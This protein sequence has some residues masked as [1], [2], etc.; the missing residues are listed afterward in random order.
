[1]TSFRLERVSELLREVASEIIRELK[2]PRLGFVTI[3]NVIVS[4]DIRHA[5]I[6]VSIMGNPDEKKDS[7]AVLN[8][9]RGF[10]RR[11]TGKRIRIKHIPELA[12]INDESIEKGSR[13]LD[14]I[15]KVTRPDERGCEEQES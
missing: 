1:M 5:K 8:N 2:D 14:I 6:Y 13:V 15:N 12:F 9:A 3:T 10:I 4:H 11:E 7:M